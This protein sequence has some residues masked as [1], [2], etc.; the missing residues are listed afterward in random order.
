MLLSLSLVLGMLIVWLAV[1]AA[2]IAV[3][4]YKAVIGLQEEEVLYIDPG[5]DRQRHEQ[6][7]LASRLDRVGKLFW[8]T[9]WI[10]IGTGVL[11]FG[12]W[13]Y[14]RLTS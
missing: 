3:A 11:T 12:V 4:V 2:C 1:T 8:I 7:A 5:E 13:V 10:S 9:L 14:E 6:A